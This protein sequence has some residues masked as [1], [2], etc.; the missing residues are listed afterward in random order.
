MQLKLTSLP[1]FLLQLREMFLGR[2][3]DNDDIINKDNMSKL[4][5]MVKVELMGMTLATAQG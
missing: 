2:K 5:F 3:M 4:A 1:T